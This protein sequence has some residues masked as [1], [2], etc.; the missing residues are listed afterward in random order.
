MNAIQLWD[1][2]KPVLEEAGFAN[3]KW[4]RDAFFARQWI[5]YEEEYGGGYK[6]ARFRQNYEKLEYLLDKEILK[7]SLVAILD[8]MM[9]TPSYHYKFEGQ[10]V[11]DLEIWEDDLKHLQK[12]MTETG[13][14]DRWEIEKV[15]NI[16]RNDGMWYKVNIMKR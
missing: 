5:D 7:A 12:R 13:M 15:D 9:F 1:K 4:F 14:L 8:E 3:E 2:L 16:K 6:G 11:F 10:N